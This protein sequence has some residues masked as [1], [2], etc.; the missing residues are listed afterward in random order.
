MSNASSPIQKDPSRSHFSRAEFIRGIKLGFPIFLGYLPVGLAFGILAY[1]KG[2]SL[3][4]TVLC[5]ATALAGAGQFIGLATMAAG[6]DALTVIVATGVVNL[7]Y[8]LFA[9]T[10]SPYLSKVPLRFMP[11]LGFTLTDEAFAVNINDLRNKTATPASMAGVGVIEWLGWV[12]GTI[13]GATCSAW[14]GNPSAW[15]VDF[16]MAAMFA[17]LFVALAE[18]IKH[19]ITGVG[20]AL[21]VFSLWVLSKFGGVTIDSNWY[22]VIAALAAA[23]IAAIIF[24]GQDDLTTIAEHEEMIVTNPLG[25]HECGD[26]NE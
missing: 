7:R 20:A 19:V 14:I 21:V 16:A 25:A 13:I 15:G 9:A 2:F 1:Q 6:G 10:I 26:R 12:G 8:V 11:W 23:T 24:K 3:V 18:N 5:S 22:I 4:Q 17:A